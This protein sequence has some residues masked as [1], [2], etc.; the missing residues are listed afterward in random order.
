L[1]DE[2]LTSISPPS[3]GRGLRVAFFTESLLPLV[4]GVS[5]TL[6]RLFHALQAAGVEFRAYSPF[7]PGDDVEWAHRVRPVR[8]F[9]FPLYRDYR[10]SV[11]GGRALSR[12]LDDYAPDIVHVV[13]PTPNAVWAQSWAR[14]HGVPV[15]GTFHTHFVSYLPYY[16]L[17][18]LQRLGWSLLRW[19]YGR[20]EATY[21]PSSSIVDELV[22]HGIPNVRLWSRGVDTQRFSPAWRDA[23]LRAAVGAHAGRPFVLMVSRLVRE[24]DLADLVPVD[25]ELRRRG[26]DYSLVLVGDGPM[27]SRLER[28]LPFAHFAGHQSGT[29][30]ARWYASADVFVFPSTTETFANVVQEAMASGV[31]AVVVDRG[32]PPGVIEPGRSG[33][34]ARAHDALH[35]ADCVQRLAQDAQLRRAMSR[36]ARRRAMARSWDTVTD[37]LIG[38]YNRI[39]RMPHARVRRLA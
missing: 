1:H 30:L 25:R 6:D 17:H 27:R 9:A 15:V 16:R 10:V 20:C 26:V 19:F 33:L 11:P 22:A 13:S 3:R 23:G 18:G 32:G 7:V 29:S 8:S 5:M 31:P 39:G 34:V 36:A 21:A 35:M 24:K 2:R 28:D 14:S 38:E 4:D 37:Q 12:E